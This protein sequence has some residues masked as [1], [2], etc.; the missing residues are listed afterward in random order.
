MQ[1]EA[2][3][4]KAK[5]PGETT[6]SKAKKHALHACSH[7]TG[8]FGGRSRAVPVEGDPLRRAFSARRT[9][10]HR[11]ALDGPQAQNNVPVTGQL[12]VRTTQALAKEPVFPHIKA[13]YGAVDKK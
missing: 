9:A 7:C 2:A 6:E 5:Q 8:C 12:D 4:T 1:S 10:R 3:L 11:R 13:A